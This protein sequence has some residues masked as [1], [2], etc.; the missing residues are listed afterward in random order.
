MGGGLLALASIGAQD[1]VLTKE[2][3]MTFFKQVYKRHTNFAI[4]TIK[5]Q[6]REQVNFGKKITLVIPRKG[7]LIGQIFFHLN[8]PALSVASGSTY[9]GWTNAIGQVII[10]YV[11][12]EIGG[13]VIDKQYGVWMSI[14][15]EL[16]LHESERQGKNISIGSY[17]NVASL[18]SNATSATEYW[19]P[20]PFWF[21]RHKSLSFPL[22]AF[23]YHDIRLNF[24]LR[25][26][27]ET[28]VFDGATDPTE[29]SIVSAEIVCHYYFLDDLERKQ[30]IK[31][32]HTYLYEELQYSDQSSIPATTVQ[33]TYKKPLEFN[34][35]VKEI[36]WVLL[37]QTSLDNNDW[38]NFSRRSDTSELIDSARLLIDGIERASSKEEGYYRLALPQ[39]HHT[40]APNKFIYIYPFSLYPEKNQP[41]GTMNFSKLDNVNLEIVVRAENNATVMQVYAINYNVA[42]ISGGMFN[43]LYST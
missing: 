3:E 9:T 22:L 40:R 5:V 27:N 18:Q 15:D 37:E 8:L 19:V 29:V 6:F 13:I 25:P 33:N 26:F 35:C 24:K 39:E 28:V 7:D 12:L 10:E 34:H 20:L 32:N 43:R 2:P 30:F 36:V 17:D 4:E 38:L 16:S 11:E 42:L 14:W 21:C 1:V 31:N 23:Q 41:S